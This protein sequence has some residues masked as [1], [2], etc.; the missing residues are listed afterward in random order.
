MGTVTVVCDTEEAMIPRLALELGGAAGLASGGVGGGARSAAAAGMEPGA[1]AAD[2]WQCRLLLLP[3]AAKHR[4]RS[5][6]R[7][8]MP[9]TTSSLL[10]KRSHLYHG[11]R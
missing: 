3:S 2:V 1:S 9:N 8:G 10:G 7:P 4:S 11:R 6:W 5:T